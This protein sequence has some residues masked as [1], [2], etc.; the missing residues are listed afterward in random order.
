MVHNHSKQVIHKITQVLCFNST[1]FL[2]HNFKANLFL[3]C[4]NIILNKDHISVWIYFS[5]N[6]AICQ[7]L[8]M[9]NH[10]MWACSEN[11]YI[12]NRNLVLYFVKKVKVSFINQLQNF[13]KRQKETYPSLHHK[14][15]QTYIKIL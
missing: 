5:F 1:T 14:L 4:S 15:I 11:E 12:Y 3:Y 2:D 7:S 13:V 10:K 8:G 9:V 6:L